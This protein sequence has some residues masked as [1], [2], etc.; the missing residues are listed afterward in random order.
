MRKLQIQFQNNNFFLGNHNFSKL[1]T[2]TSTTKRNSLF[3]I[4]LFYIP[5]T[6]YPNKSISLENNINSIPIPSILPVNK[7]LKKNQ[8]NI[9][10]EKNQNKK[11]KE[12]KLPL[13]K[14]LLDDN[15]KKQV[16][17]NKNKNK[18]KSEN[19]INWF[20]PELKIF[21]LPFLFTSTGKWRWVH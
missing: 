7:I 17:E 10:Q 3:F 19:L 2:T 6:Q 5:P 14:K 1:P 11:E 8:I 16:K 20:E 13:E 9:S 18:K 12:K 4:F 21:F 15:I